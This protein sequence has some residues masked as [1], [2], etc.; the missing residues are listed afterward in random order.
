MN[1]R[2]SLPIVPAPV[3]LVCGHPQGS[4]H[5]EECPVPEHEAMLT[6]DPVAT[7]VHHIL[8]DCPLCLL[9]QPVA[10]GCRCG[11]CCERMIIE[12]TAFDAEREPKIR[13]RGRIMDE[14]GLVPAQD[15]DWLLN[16]PQGP[17]VFFSRDAE[18]N[19]ICEIYATRPLACQQFNCDDPDDDRLT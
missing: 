15:A 2:T 5:D 7:A 9:Q 17:C 13:Q 4:E 14:G 1:H 19:G 6:G 18:G 16:G 12:A 10:C 8:G 11:H 3:C